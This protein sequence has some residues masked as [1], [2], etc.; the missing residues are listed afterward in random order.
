MA[1]MPNL[2]V[3]KKSNLSTLSSRG[4]TKSRREIFLGIRES[5]SHA[6]VFQRSQFQGKEERG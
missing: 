2:R 1:G 5:L 6:R 3:L 4:E